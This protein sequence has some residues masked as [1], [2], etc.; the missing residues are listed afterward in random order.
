MTTAFN[1]NSN[2]QNDVCASKSK[3]A[4]SIANERHIAPWFG[5]VFKIAVDDFN[6]REIS[7][8]KIDSNGYRFAFEKHLLLDC[9]AFESRDIRPDDYTMIGTGYDHAEYIDDELKTMI[10]KA[11]I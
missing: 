5:A 2:G 8:T 1:T 10:S 3:S 11:E 4:I 6:K 7:E 9:R